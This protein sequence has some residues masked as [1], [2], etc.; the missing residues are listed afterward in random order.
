MSGHTE[1]R[2]SG[3]SWG[4]WRDAWLCATV[5]WYRVRGELY[6]GKRVLKVTAQSARW[7]ACMNLIGL[8]KE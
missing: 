8:Y 4:Y 7:S 3:A 2:K 5:C 6:V 1:E